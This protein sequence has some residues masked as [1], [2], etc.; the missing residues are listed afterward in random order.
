MAIFFWVSSHCLPYVFWVLISSSYR[1]TS[2]IGLGP[3]VCLVAQLVKNL[4][5]MQEAWF[6]T[7]GWENPLEKGK[8]TRSSILAWKFHGLYSPWSCKESHMTDWLSLSLS[9]SCLCDQPLIHVQ[10]PMD[11]N[12]MDYSPPALP[13]HGILQAKI[14]G[15]RRSSRPMYGIRSPASLALSG[16]FYLG[17][18][19]PHNKTP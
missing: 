6:R 7:L 19:S 12:P 15:F 9:L 2:Y 11:F 5:A 18:H 3:R 13:V 16:Q 1:D 17:S 10:G 8:A 4:P 14:L